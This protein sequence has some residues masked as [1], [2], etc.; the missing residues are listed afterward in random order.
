MK[1][2]FEAL[3]GKCGVTF[4][5]VEPFPST[6]PESRPEQIQATLPLEFLRWF[7]LILT[8]A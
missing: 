7:A 4:H 1:R 6:L 3:H 8:T 5:M 2:L